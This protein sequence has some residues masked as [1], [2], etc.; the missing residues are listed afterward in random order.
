MM[1]RFP[2]QTAWYLR[3]ELQALYGV[4]GPD[5]FDASGSNNT[6]ATADAIPK[7]SSGS[8]LLAV[9]DLTSLNDV[10]YYKFSAPALT[11]LLS[12]VVRVKASGISLL[13]PSVTVYDSWGRVVTSAVTTDTA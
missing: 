9:G 4:R 1:P 8:Q 6:M 7:A 11:S 3:P 2:H 10:D 5:A 13:T 12:I